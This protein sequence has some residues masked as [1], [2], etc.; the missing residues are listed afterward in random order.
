MLTMLAP[1]WI[2]LVFEADSDGGDGSLGGMVAAALAITA[3]AFALLTRAERRRA[4]V[5]R[6]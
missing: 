3:G 2:E 1:T 4:A 5:R 6:V